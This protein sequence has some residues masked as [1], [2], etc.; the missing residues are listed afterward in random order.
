[1]ILTSCVQGLPIKEW[2][3]EKPATGSR[4]GVGFFLFGLPFPE[5]PSQQCYWPGC[6]GGFSLKKKQDHRGRKCSPKF[7]NQFSND[8]SSLLPSASG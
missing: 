2:E 3:Q 1:M 8:V 7:A 5:S 4:G 6:L